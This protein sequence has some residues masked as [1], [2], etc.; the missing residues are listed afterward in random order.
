MLAAQSRSQRHQT[1]HPTVADRP[2]ELSRYKEAPVIVTGVELAQFLLA[3]HPI[4]ALV[5]IQGE[6]TGRNREAVAI[7]LQH[8][9]AQAI[10][11]RSPR[12]VLDARDGRLRAQRRTGDRRPVQRQL[13]DGIL[14]QHV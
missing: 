13:E 9:L 7:K 1:G 10:E 5:E 2:T 6:M 4:K 14:A 11:V 12:Q 8:R 3:V